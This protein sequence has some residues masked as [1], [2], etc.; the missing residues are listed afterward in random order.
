MEPSCIRQTLIPGTSAL[1]SDYSYHFDRISNFY[2]WS[3]YHP[4]SYRGAAQEIEYPAERRKALVAALARQNGD[5]ESLRRLAQ[6]GTVAVVTG[7]QVG[8]FSG[9]AYTVFKAVTAVKLAQRLNEDGIPAVPVFWLATEDHDFA[10]VNHAWI[11][12]S[13]G[14]PQKLEINGRNGGRNGPQQP[15]GGVQIH[16]PPIDQLKALLDGLPFADEV[17][18]A[19]TEAYRNG[20]TM[21]SAFQEL[22]QKIFKNLGLLYV[23]PLDPAIRE[24]AGPFLADAVTKTRELKT[25]LLKRNSEL[26]QRK[27]H[28]QVHIEQETSLFFLLENGRRISLKEQDGSFIAKDRTFSVQDL[29]NRAAQLSPNAVLRPVMQDYLLP[30]VAYVG[31]P[32]ELAYFAQSAVLYPPLLGRM[33]V[34]VARNSFTLLDHR[35]QKLLRRYGL[36]VPDLFDTQEGVQAKIS[37]KLVPAEMEGHFSGAREIIER[38]WDTLL[39]KLLRLDP[40]L[41]AASEKSKTKALYQLDKI[42]R[43]TARETLRRNARAQT[44]AACLSNLIYPHQH[45]QERF[46][47]ILPFLAKHGMDLPERLL[48]AANLDCPDHMVRVI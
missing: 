33:P 10:E 1:F 15:V 30:T 46:Y 29:Q 16:E 41:K 47:S 4:D 38:Q 32:A 45:L 26:A 9:P 36:R 6:P 20:A 44:E 34:I 27:Y 14:T 48:E 37:A 12:D 2:R 18:Q 25:A 8:L 40:T 17:V 11:F 43:K 21:G 13:A 23:D 28:A 5:S 22:L 39:T 7:Q 31:G 35:A 3:P 42:Q 19:V 24:I